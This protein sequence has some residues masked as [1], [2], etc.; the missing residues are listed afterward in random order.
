MARNLIELTYLQRHAINTMY[1]REK[2][3]VIIRLKFYY[4]QNVNL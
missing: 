1:A 2:A 4:N 3:D